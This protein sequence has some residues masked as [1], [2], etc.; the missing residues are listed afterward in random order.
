ML[1][2][3]QGG[4]AECHGGLRHGW[5]RVACRRAPPLPHVSN[6]DEDSVNQHAVYEAL[7][8]VQGELVAAGQ[9]ED[10]NA[11]SVAGHQW[12]GVLLDGGPEQV[13]T[14]LLASATR[15]QG[16]IAVDTQTNT[17]RA[18]AT[19]LLGT[20]ALSGLRF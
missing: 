19:L 12:G 5:V 2:L 10:A 6:A 16:P 20:S 9:L 8:A 3:R 15:T 4:R 14:L 11:S 13:R 7:R 1:A 17:R 18:Q